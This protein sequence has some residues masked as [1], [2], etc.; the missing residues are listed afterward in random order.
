MA[1][2]GATVDNTIIQANPNDLVTQMKIFSDKLAKKPAYAP[3]KTENTIAAVWMGINDV[4]GVIG[5]SDMKSKLDMATKRYF[6]LSQ[7]LYNAGIRKIIFLTVP[8]KFLI[9]KTNEFD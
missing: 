3:W 6:E 2:G 5:R 7:T 1:V 9:I 4:G 8:R